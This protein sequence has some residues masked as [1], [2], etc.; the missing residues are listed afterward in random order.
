MFGC[1][2]EENPNRFERLK[3]T[4]PNQ[5]KYCMGKLG[6][7]EVLDYIGVKY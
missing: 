1:H 3:Y 7:K 2:L 4:H 5:Y 6:L